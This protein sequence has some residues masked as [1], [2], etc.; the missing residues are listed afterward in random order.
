MLVVWEKG[1]GSVV[2]KSKDVAEK[3]MRLRKERQNLEHE[4]GKLNKLVDSEATILESEVSMLRK[5]LMTK[6]PKKF[7]ESDDTSFESAISMLYEGPRIEESEKLSDSKT[8]LLESKIGA[9]RE[10]V[11]MLGIDLLANEPLEADSKKKTWKHFF[12]HFF[13]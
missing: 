10:E 11:R 4:I 7:T 3:I 12:R 8:A 5:E 2:G 13:R 9:L 6:E 1:K